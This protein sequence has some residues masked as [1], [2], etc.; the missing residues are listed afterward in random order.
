MELPVEEGQV[1]LTRKYVN[2][3]SIS[4][5]NGETVPAQTIKKLAEGLIDIHGQHEHQSLLYPKN[6]LLILDQFGGDALAEKKQA[7][8]RAYRLYEEQKKALEQLTMDETERAKELDFLQFEIHEIEEAALIAGEDEQLEEEYR[9]LSNGQKIMEAVGEAYELTGYSQGA[10]DRTGRAV[11][12]LRQVARYDSQ[13]EEISGQLEEVDDL[14]NDVNRAISDYMEDFSFSEEE[15][16]RIE[17]RLNQINR[18]KTKYGK[19]IEE[20]LAYKQEKE[21]RLSVLTDYAARMAELENSC[22]RM[23]KELRSAADALSEIRRE[24]GKLLGQEI[25]KALEDLNFLNVEFDLQFEQEDFPGANGQD[26]VCFMLS[27]NPGS[28]MRPLQDVASGGELSRIMLAIK[29]VM[30]WKDQIGTL[31]FDEIDT[32]I[33]GRTAQ[34]VSEKMA[35]IA[36][37]RQVICISHLAQIASMAD[38]HFLIEKQADSSGTHTSVTLLD[39]E[40]SVNELARM[41]GGAKITDRVVESAREM[42]ELALAAKY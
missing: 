1:I 28:P 2:G 11:K 4:R 25:G 27:V 22:R 16:A 20:I 37:S 5:I 17:S 12:A 24:K 7:C 18:L 29:A 38:S 42:K 13:L 39:T 26:K 30:A 14:L 23:E 8:A 3:R 32:G 40:G 10:G 31:I 35:M 41:L 36:R 19:T 9:R 33:S 6:H 15:F 21:E 34:K